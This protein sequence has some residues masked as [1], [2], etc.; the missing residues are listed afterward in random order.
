M[1]IYFYKYILLYKYICENK[2]IFI[3]ISYILCRKDLD[4][5]D[6]GEDALLVLSAQQCRYL[7][8]AVDQLSQLVH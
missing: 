1:L 4:L 3:Q 7:C 8:I 5:Q 2:Y 6:E